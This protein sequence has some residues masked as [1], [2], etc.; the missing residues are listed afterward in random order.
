MSKVVTQSFLQGKVILEKLPR[1][2][3]EDG[4]FFGGDER[5][6]VAMFFS[7]KNVEYVEYAEFKNKGVKRGFHYHNNFTEYACV[8]YGEIRFVGK[9]VGSDDEIEVLLS[10][11][12]ILTIKPGVAHGFLALEKSGIIYAGNGQ[13]PFKDRKPFT[14]L[15]LTTGT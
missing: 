12:D 1:E 4:R 10:E 8:L 13:S 9:V 3:S 15:P 2:A 6:D 11:G 14:E 5:G 7:G